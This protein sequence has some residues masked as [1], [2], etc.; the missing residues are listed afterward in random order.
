MAATPA[1]DRCT[2]SAT[3]SRT[4]GRGRSRRA[5]AGG[6]AARLGAQRGLPRPQRLVAVVRGRLLGTRQQLLRGMGRDRA[7]PR[8]LPPVDGRQRPQRLGAG[9]LAGGRAMTELD[10]TPE[11]VM[12]IAA[13]R[14]LVDGEV[15][16]VGVGPPNAAANLAR[17]LDHPGCVLIYESGAIGA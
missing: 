13:A 7:R 2:A 15:V 1:W 10:P 17:R 3:P 14:E 11:E 9:R 8:P 12:T 6:R 4:A 5:A 16:L